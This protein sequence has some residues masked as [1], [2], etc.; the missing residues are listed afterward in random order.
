MRTIPIALLLLGTLAAAQTKAPPR[1]TPAPPTR[2]VADPDEGS[3]S[4]DTYTNRFF[5]FEYTFPE[6]LDV[7]DQSSFMEGQLDQSN[8]SFI[9]LAAF[10]MAENERGR[11]GVV[12]IADNAAAYPGL[13]DAGGYLDKVARPLAEKQGFRVMIPARPVELAGQKFFR[14]D[15]TRDDVQQAALI[16]IRRGYALSFTL[17]APN[18]H[19]LQVLA[20]SLQT[21]KFTGVALPAAPPRTK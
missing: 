21:L 8:R 16:T 11:E 6:H 18:H 7:Q 1:K 19:R 17:I 4:D 9:L 10:G 13:A 12:L 20:D 5:G 3:V 2:A 14:M 15:F